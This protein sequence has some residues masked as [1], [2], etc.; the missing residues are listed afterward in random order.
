MLQSDI[1][2][3]YAA[4][5][6]RQFSRGKPTRPDLLIKNLSN[7]IRCRAT[8][9]LLGLWGIA[10]RP[11]VNS[12]DF[13]A[14][15]Q[16]NNLLQKVK[17]CYSPGVDVTLIVATG[18]G[19]HNGIDLATIES[20]AQAAEALFDEF[21]FQHSR[22][23]VV[24]ERGRIDLKVVESAYHEMTTGWWENVPHAEVLEKQAAKHNSR[25]P[26]REA[27]QQYVV[28]RKLENP[29]LETTYNDSIFFTY[30][31]KNDRFLLPKLPIIHL[32]SV[33]RGTSHP[34]WFMDEDILRSR[35]VR[36][37]KL[38]RVAR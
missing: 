35:Q 29:I 33:K 21:G 7:V 22:L 32:Y 38:N 37:M 13:S 26:P 9:R 23:D 36:K 25:L 14:C 1:M 17:S 5:K 18:H 15:E 4:L 8:I 10:R 3:I 6:S 27:A 30:S 12:A 19:L 31:G 11:M 2:D 34:P 20:Y 28:M 16:L 24:W